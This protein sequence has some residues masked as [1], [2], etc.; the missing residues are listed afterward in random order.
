[1]KSEPLISV[2]IPTY[3]RPH[4]IKSAFESVAAQSYA[5]WELIIVDDNGKGTEGGEATE[6]AV[7]EFYPADNVVY[8]QLETNMGACAARN[9]GIEISTGEYIAFLDD[10]DEWF[11]D[12][13]KKQIA[14]IQQDNADICYSDMYLSNTGRQQY[15]A[16]DIQGDHYQSLLIRGY[17]ICTSALLIKKQTLIDIQGFDQSLPSMQDY[18]LLIRLC[19]KGKVTVIK[20]ALFNYKMADDG[21]SANLDAKINGHAGIINKY[22]DTYI[23]LGL[24]D[25]LSRQLE[26]LGDFTLRKGQ[27]REALKHYSDAA[28]I[29]GQ[30]KRL[31]L[32]QVF[33]VLF[34]SWPLETFMKFRHKA[35]TK[36]IDVQK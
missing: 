29:A 24:K 23:K 22:R 32:K 7:N 26:C 11:K 30:H 12:K 28:K 1:M 15:Y 6:K 3:K 20:E 18:D 16:H 34:G 35:A 36:P 25:G 13:L 19:E 4:L 5:N 9:T 27:R 14:Q 17:G 33:G 8:Q 10:D 21:I 31:M 2:V